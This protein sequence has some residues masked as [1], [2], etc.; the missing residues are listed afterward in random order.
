MLAVEAAMDVRAAM[1]AIVH[2]G[3]KAFKLDFIATVVT[4]H[5]R[6]SR[7]ICSSPVKKIE[8]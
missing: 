7:L 2:A 4:N 8:P 5:D 3:D 1:R 6:P